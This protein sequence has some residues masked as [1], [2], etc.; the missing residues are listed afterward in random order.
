MT[1]K[2][3]YIT[4]LQKKYKIVYLHNPKHFFLNTL[5]IENLPGDRKL[6]CAYPRKHSKQFHHLALLKPL[7]K[8]AKPFNGI[9]QD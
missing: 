1:T 6:L 9:L 2:K 4:Q 5:H 3:L 8:K 7:V